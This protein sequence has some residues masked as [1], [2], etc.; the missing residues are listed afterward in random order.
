MQKFSEKSGF[1]LVE[2]ITTMTILSI[3]S[4]FSIKPMG[5]F[6]GQARQAEAKG[7][8][9]HIASTQSTYAIAH[10]QYA[11]LANYGGGQG[12]CDCGTKTACKNAVATAKDD[13]IKCTGLGGTWDSSNQC[14]GGG[15]LKI[16]G[17]MQMR[18]NYVIEGTSQ[19][20]YAHATADGDNLV[21][22]CTID[23]TGKRKD[24]KQYAKANPGEGSRAAT[25]AV[26]VSAASSTTDGHFIT[27][28]QGLTAAY[29][30]V[31][32]CD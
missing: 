25:A 18:Y 4:V 9:A 28:E 24:I 8:L 12:S 26:V 19:G 27:E 10:S 11:K 2:M 16:S 17:C 23:K 3:L 32:N 7:T 5:K 20:F 30:A 31:A 21:F 22:G 1:T 29:D 14:N 6:V 15:W 13:A